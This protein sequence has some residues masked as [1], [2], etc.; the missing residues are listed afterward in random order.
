V[1]FILRRDHSSDF[2]K[3]NAS[4]NITLQ[5]VK[6]NHHMKA[7][8]V[9]EFG[10]PAVLK[11]EELPKLTPEAGQVVVRTQAIGVNPVDGF[12]C[13][14]YLPNLPL[15]FTPGVD[16]AGFVESIGAGVTSVKV[17]ERVYGGWSLS[18]TYTEQ[19]LYNAAQVFPLPDNVLFSQSAGVMM[20]YFTAHYAL[21]ARG[22]GVPGETVLVHG[23]SGGVGT[24]TVQMAKA[25]GFKVIGTAST[26]RG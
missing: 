24:A 19:V 16:A 8:R 17:G 14:G 12:L 25:A 21:F 22:F 3:F 26:E 13:S 2:V 9:H 23:A 11:L 15:P 20:T 7:V 4:K 10:S 5:S 18:G 1:S 6:G